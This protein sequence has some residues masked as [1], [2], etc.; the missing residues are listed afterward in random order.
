MLSACCWH[1]LCL[2]ACKAV[3]RPKLRA[4]DGIMIVVLVVVAVEGLPL[5]ALSDHTA[6]GCT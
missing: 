6:K 4:C 5:F 3:I 2:V 1:L